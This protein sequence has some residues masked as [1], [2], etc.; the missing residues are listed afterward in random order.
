LLSDSAL[1]KAIIRKKEDSVEWLSKSADFFQVSD[2]GILLTTLVV[3]L[4]DN[5][6]IHNYEPVGLDESDR[7]G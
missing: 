1:V 3:T 6:S 4:V 5:A 7:A 2:Q